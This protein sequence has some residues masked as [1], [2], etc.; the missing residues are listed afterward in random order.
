MIASPLRNRNLIREMTKREIVGR[1]R[2]SA[3]GI[4]W[5]LFNPMLLLAVYTF[6]F[7]VVFKARWGADTGSKGEFAVILFAGMIVYGLFAE[8]LN[9]AP[10]LVL[11][12]P[13]YV[14][15]VVFPLEILPWVALGV[16][17]FHAAM[18]ALVLVIFLLFLNQALPWTILLLPVVITP[19]LLMTLGFTWFLSS[20][21]VFLRDVSQ[22]VGLLTTVLMFASPVFYS[23]A[24]I[25][26]QYRAFLYINP[27][28]VLIEQVRGV[29]IWNVVPDLAVLTLVTGVSMLIAWIGFVFFQKTR[30]G[31]SDVM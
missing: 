5:S 22:L 3:L 9:H 6:V 18:S 29:L 1:Y 10:S 28:A 17:L 4:I 31:F 13:N 30:S 26:E 12:H 19:L 14:K 20:L 24:S 25:P 21:G 16:A 7:S 8:C 15:K 11:S 23:I 27:L 2:G